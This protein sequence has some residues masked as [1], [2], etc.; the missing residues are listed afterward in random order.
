M[1][2]LPILLVGEVGNRPILSIEVAVPTDELIPSGVESPSEGCTQHA[3]CGE[4]DP[5]KVLARRTL[6]NESSC[7]SPRLRGFNELCSIPS[8]V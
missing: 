6:N 1:D 3:V 5:S 8:D 7:V 4:T 2:M